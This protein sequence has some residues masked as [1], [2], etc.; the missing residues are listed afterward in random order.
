MCVSCFTA[1][2]AVG[3]QS[4]GFAAAA[5]SGARR[6]RLLRLGVAPSSR[7]VRDW[8]ESAA[9]LATLGHDPVKLLGPR[10][11]DLAVREPILR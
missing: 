11:E 7:R 4:V 9:F 10:P 6:W 8:D 3:L 2:D 5:L 1:V